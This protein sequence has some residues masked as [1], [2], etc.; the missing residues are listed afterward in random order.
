MALLTYSYL[1]GSTSP[2]SPSIPSTDPGAVPTR[3]S[4]HGSPEANGL[5]NRVLFTFVF[6]EMMSWF[7]I[8]VTLREE[9]PAVVEKMMR[10]RA[11]E[12]ERERYM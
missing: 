5:G 4:A 9:R 7:W 2:F 8:W 3:N 11:R 10:E 6:I 1:S 12:R